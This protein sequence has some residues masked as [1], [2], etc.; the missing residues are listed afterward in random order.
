MASP[1]EEQIL[2]RAKELCHEDGHAWFDDA[3]QVNP[4]KFGA[5]T[6]RAMTS[7]ETR[8]WYM[9]KALQQLLEEA[10]HAKR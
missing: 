8:Q 10:A 2:K 6:G 9:N 4:V 3:P 1:T 7:D 5:K